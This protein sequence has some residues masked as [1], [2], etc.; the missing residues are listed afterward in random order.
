MGLAG[1]PERMTCVMAVLAS[2]RNNMHKGVRNESLC[3]LT[4]DD[5]DQVGAT[6]GTDGVDDTIGGGESESS[7]GSS[8]TRMKSW[9]IC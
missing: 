8:T 4:G 6:D 2:P 9:L 5:D 7:I 1:Q 3:E